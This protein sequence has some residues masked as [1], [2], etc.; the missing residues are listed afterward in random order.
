MAIP[1]LFP[2][3]QLVDLLPQSGWNALLA[4]GML[5]PIV[6]LLI[7]FA[8]NNSSRWKR[9]AVGIFYL[10]SLPLAGVMFLAQ[11]ENPMAV[12]SFLL[13]L[14]VGML[15]GVAVLTVPLRRAEPRGFEIRPKGDGE[16]E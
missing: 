9:T 12:C 6:G 15:L 3:A 10:I 7:S 13:L 14:P 11:T 8:I 2:L 5:A 1:S 16:A 4:A